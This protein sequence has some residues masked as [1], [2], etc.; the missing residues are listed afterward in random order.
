MSRFHHGMSAIQ[1]AVTDDA[2]VYKKAPDY[3]KGI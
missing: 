2:N 1:D 3:T